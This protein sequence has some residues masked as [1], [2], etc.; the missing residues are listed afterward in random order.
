MRAVRKGDNRCYSGDSAKTA[1]AATVFVRHFPGGRRASHCAPLTHRSSGGFAII[2]YLSR[3]AN[4]VKSALS[5]GVGWVDRNDIDFSSGSSI[6]SV[7]PEGPEGF[8]L[9]GKINDAFR[10]TDNITHLKP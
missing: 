5:P 4:D 1:H 3:K 7:T 6:R 8:A 9:M 10:P 2:E